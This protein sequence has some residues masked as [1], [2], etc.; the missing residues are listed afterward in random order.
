MDTARGVSGKRGALARAAGAALKVLG[1]FLI[2]EP[3]WMLLPFAGFLYGSVMQIDTLARNPATAWLTHFVLPVLALGWVG[4]L[5]VVVGLAV[6]LVGAGQVY[7]ARIRRSGLV[8]QGLYRFVRHPQYVALSLFGLGIL[9]TWGRAITFLAFCVMMF[10]YYYLARSEERNCLRLFGRAYEEYRE[11]TSFIL[12]GD[13]RLRPLRAY[14]P[15]LPLAAPLRVAGAFVATMALCLALLWLIDAA[16]TAV[17]TV[18]Y[19]T[20]TVPLGGA[21]QPKAAEAPAMASGEAAGVSFVHAGRLAVVRGPYRNAWQTGFAERVLLRLRQSEALGSFLAFLDEPN[22]DAAIVF[23]SPYERPDQ[24][25]TPGGQA[26]SGEAGR[27]GPPADPQGPDRVRLIVLR[28]RLA[29]GASVADAFADKGKRQIRGACIAPVDLGRADGE[30][31]VDGQVLRPG[32]AFPGEERWDFLMQQLAA[33]AGAGR[34]RDPGVVVPGLAPRA[35]LVL[36]KAPILRTRLE[37][38]FAQE[39]LDRLTES[40]T[41]CRRLRAVGVGEGIVPVA[42]PTPGPDWYH[43]H[44]GTPQI[45]VC[46]FLVRWRG[47]EGFEGLFRPGASRPLVAAFFADMEFAIER[48]KDSITG[49]RTIGPR[50]DLEE[51]WRFFLSGL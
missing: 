14:L 51:R 5:L 11:S 18:P 26:G 45:S 15:R 3:V 50:R 39:I 47:E 41:F 46:V 23:C 49:V 16:K 30:D 7:R 33:G 28:C 29:A 48:P 43:E 12:P 40:E 20:A 38:A 44:H 42:F 36:V 31:F 2:L 34:R 10:V 22:G 21:E 8:T 4:P 6:F 32:P 17:R 1:L 37:P 35:T 24:P 13:R 19:L 25:G 9:L 27:R